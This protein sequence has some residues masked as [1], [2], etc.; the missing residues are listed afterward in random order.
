MLSEVERAFALGSKSLFGGGQR[1]LARLDQRGETLTLGAY[2]RH[3]I[4]KRLALGRDRLPQLHEIRK[5]RGKRFGF[6]AHLRQDRTE[7]HGGSD[8]GKHVFRRDQK[9]RRRLAPHPLQGGE[10]LG[11]DRAAACKRKL[12]RVL[13]PG[14]RVEPCLRFADLA[15][16]RVDNLRRVEKRRGKLRPVGADRCDLGFDPPALLLRCLERIFHAPQFEP[17]SAQLR[18]VLARVRRHRLTRLRR[19]ASGRKKCKT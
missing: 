16:A 18:A 15:F 3:A 2:L 1:R 7:Q 17:A 8:R 13:R 6:A 14:Q 10:D 4:R 19:K 5:V 11:N 12:D 9:R